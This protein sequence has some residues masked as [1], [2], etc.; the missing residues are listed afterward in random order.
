MNLNFINLKGSSIGCLRGRN[1]KTTKQYHAK[2][3]SA[4]C[5]LPIPHSI[6]KTRVQSNPQGAKISQ[7]ARVYRTAT[8]QGFQGENRRKR[9]NKMLS[10]RRLCGAWCTS[11]NDVTKRVYVYATKTLPQSFLSK[12]STVEFGTVIPSVR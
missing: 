12:L 11:L 7:M 8:T 6:G 5:K 9:G 1:A 10:M 4:V 2:S 3:E